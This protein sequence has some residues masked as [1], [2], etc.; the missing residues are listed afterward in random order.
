MN[1]ESNSLTVAQV[2][3][4]PPMDLFS[5][6]YV[7]WMIKQNKTLAVHKMYVW[8]HGIDSTYDEIMYIISL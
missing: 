8:T 7:I 5:K 3:Q 4:T 2:L 6:P 1:Q